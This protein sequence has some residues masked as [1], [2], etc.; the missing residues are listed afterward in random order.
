[1]LAHLFA[2]YIASSSSGRMCKHFSACLNVFSLAC[3]RQFTGG[4]MVGPDRF[5][6]DISVPVMPGN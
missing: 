1:M 2:V 3:D 6:V 4:E 5:P